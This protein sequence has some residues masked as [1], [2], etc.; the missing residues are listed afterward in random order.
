[1]RGSLT[2]Y[3]LSGLQNSSRRRSVFLIFYFGHMIGHRISCLLCWM[4]GEAK[5][6]IVFYVCLFA[7]NVS[8]LKIEL[9][10]YRVGIPLISFCGFFLLE[11]TIEYV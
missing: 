11:S 9:S 8:E 4:Y 2:Y 3:R 5:A 6:L 1:M 10:N 7:W